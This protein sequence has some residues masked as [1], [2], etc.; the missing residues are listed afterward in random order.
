LTV[1]KTYRTAKFCST[2]RYIPQKIEDIF[3]SDNGKVEE[4]TLGESICR[5][6]R[7][8]RLQTLFQVLKVMLQSREYRFEKFGEH[9]RRK[10]PERH[11]AKQM[12]LLRKESNTI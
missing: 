11:R 7:N 1:P 4:H 6:Y 10:D 3:A 9:I 2:Y 5:P 8:K 12:E